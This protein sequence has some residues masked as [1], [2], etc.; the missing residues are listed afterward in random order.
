M[1]QSL[2]KRLNGN[3]QEVVQ[4]ARAFGE[5]ATMR[6]YHIAEYVSLRNYLEL[7]APGE[8][9]RFAMPEADDFTDTRAFDNLVEAFI[10]KITNMQSQYNDALAKIEQLESQLEKESKARW[11]RTRPAIETLM[12]L[13]NS[14][15][16]R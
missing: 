3:W 15:E 12:N 2:E 16:E 11:K 14:A 6:E 7:H 9:F 13:C 8:K 1:G 4:Y 5:E 10:R